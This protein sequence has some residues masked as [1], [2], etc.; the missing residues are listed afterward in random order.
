MRHGGNLTT[1]CN[2]DNPKKDPRLFSSV[3]Y[4]GTTDEFKKR[5]GLEDKRINIADYL[6]ETFPT[7]GAFNRTGLARLFKT[8]GFKKGAEVGVKMGLYSKVLCEENP[9]MN[10]KSIDPWT[11]TPNIGWDAQEETFRM[12]IKNL[13]PFN[14]EI[15][16]KTSMQA[17]AEDIPKW[18]LDFVYIDADH[19]FNHVMQDIIT[20]SDRVRPGGIVSGHDY[21]DIDVKTAVDAYVRIHGYELFTTLVQRTVR[22]MIEIDNSNP[23]YPSKMI[24]TD[25]ASSWFF[26]KPIKES[27]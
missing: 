21:D 26:A 25:L 3:D 15:I 23:V 7:V 1:F 22:P 19:S 11:M 16:R 9:D 18:S 6:H 24:E 10:L 12:A 4:W 8:L 13:S 27:E 17:A 20:W 14:A 5:I 2:F